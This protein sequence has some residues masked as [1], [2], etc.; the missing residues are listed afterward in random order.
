MCTVRAVRV[1]RSLA[2]VGAGLAMTALLGCG[3]GDSS[4]ATVSGKIAYKGVPLTSGTLSLYPASVSAFP[5]AIKADG[6]FNASGVPVGMMGVGIA[7]EAPTPPPGETSVPV[8][9]VA[10]P[11]RY[12]NPQTSGLTWEIKGGKNPRDFDLTD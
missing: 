3:G 6:T 5:I 7:T 8:K 11:L 1:W 2:A 10:V 4:K 9:V 12:K